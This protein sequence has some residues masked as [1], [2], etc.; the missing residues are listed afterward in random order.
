LEWFDVRRSDLAGKSADPHI[1]YAR[2][3]GA[4][5]KNYGGG[6]KP[7]RWLKSGDLELSSDM[8]MLSRVDGRSYTGVVTFTTGFDKQRHA[9]LRNA[10]KSTTHVDQ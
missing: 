4:D 5:V 7:L 8:M 9:A 6:T 1:K 10:G 2:G 3:A